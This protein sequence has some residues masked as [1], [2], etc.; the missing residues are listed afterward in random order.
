MA[1]QNR[2]FRDNIVDPEYDRDDGDDDD[3]ADDQ[4]EADNVNNAGRGGNIQNNAG[5]AGAGNNRPER[6][7]HRLNEHLPPNFAGEQHEDPVEWMDLFEGHAVLNEWNDA[8]KFNRFFMFLRKPAFYWYKSFFARAG[9]PTTW[10]ELRAEFLRHYRSEDYNSSLLEKLNNRV[11]GPSESILNYF[12]EIVHICD[13]IDPDMDEQTKLRFVFRG[14]DSDSYSLFYPLVRSTGYTT[15][16]FYHQV[17]NYQAMLKNK[18]RVGVKR[19]LKATKHDTDRLP[20]YSANFSEQSEPPYKKR[21]NDNNEKFVSREEIESIVE[22]AVKSATDSVREEMLKERNN[23]M[24][25]WRFP[26]STFPMA[27][28]VYPFFNPPMPFPSSPMLNAAPRFPNNRMLLPPFNSDTSKG[29]WPRTEDGRPI[30]VKCNKPGHISKMC[31]V[32]LPVSMS[33]QT[34]RMLPAPSQGQSPSG[35][36]TSARNEEN[37]ITK[38]LN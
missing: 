19:P 38:N 3:E 37:R 15:D 7:R 27:P 9:R 10:R 28:N 35:A 29:K 33:S 12:H 14:L 20:C 1:A 8:D 17:K 2:L 24:M 23:S 34:G 18:Q 21:A 13:Q 25:P 6:R 16:N 11:K 26:Q 4:H 5:R 31:R 32:N 22:K 30:C 36:S